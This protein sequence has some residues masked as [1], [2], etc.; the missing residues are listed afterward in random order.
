MRHRLVLADIE[1]PEHR[2]LGGA[3]A[4]AMVDRIDQHRDPEHVGQQDEL[5][6]ARRAFLAGP[7]QEIDRLLPFL[8]GEIGLADVVVQRAAPVR[9]IRNFSRGSGVSSKLCDRPLRSVRSRRIGAFSV[10]SAAAR[11]HH[12]R[13]DKRCA[14]SAAPAHCGPAYSTADMPLSEQRRAFRL[15]S[16]EPRQPPET[17][18][19]AD[20]IVPCR[21]NPASRRAVSAGMSKAGAATGSTTT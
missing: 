12:A 8:E 9:C 14:A 17:R 1:R 18:S 19:T 10:L 13:C 7:G 6:P 2:G 3:V 20:V 15:S 16:A 21:S 5:L 11:L 4:L